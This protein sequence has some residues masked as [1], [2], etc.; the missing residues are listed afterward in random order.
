M[1]KSGPFFA[2]A[3]FVEATYERMRNFKEKIKTRNYFSK[4]FR[5]TS[6]WR[7]IITELQK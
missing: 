2:E 4:L 1:K 6:L 7:S 5:V 3:A